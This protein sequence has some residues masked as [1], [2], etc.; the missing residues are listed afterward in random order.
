MQCS[1]W[2]KEGCALMRKMLLWLAVLFMLLVCTP[3]M[4]E[5]Y[6]IDELYASIEIPDDYIVL[7]PK[8]LSNYAQWLE[9]RESS[10][11]KT[12]SDFESRG[13]KLQAWSEKHD[14]CFELRATQSQ[15]TE[16]IFDVN[17][18]SEAVRREYRT[19][20]Y[21][22]NEYAGYDFSSSEWKNTGEN[23]R[24][25]ILK[26]VKRDN[27]EIL[28]RGFMRRTI[29]NGY[30]ID[31]DMQIHGRSA[32]DKDNSKLNKIWETFDFIEILAMPPKAAAKIAVTDEPPEETNKKSFAIEGTA[33]PGVKFTAVVM[34]L[35]DPEPVVTEA[36]AG[37][38][39]TFSLP[40]TFSKD[41]VY[42]ITLT[43]EYQDDEVMEMVYPV[44]YQ[45]TL[46]AV[47]FTTKPGEVAT[48]DSVKLAGTG[49]PGAS[50]QVFVN[51][52]AVMTKKVTAEGRFSITVE[53]EEEGPYDVALVFSKKNLADRRF[54]F[55]FTRKW[56]DADMMAYLK[57]QSISPTYSQLVKGMEKYEG[58][59][60]AFK[61]Y[62]LDVSESGDEYIV[63]MA[64]NRS[65]GKY[66]NIILVT[67][68]E[69]PNF[70]LEDRVMMYGTCEGMSLS[71]GTVD[72]DVKEESY[73]CF[74]LLLFA[75]LE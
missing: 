50:I 17:E 49:E 28:H 29:R 48:A 38:N 6:I 18:Q 70:E 8:N 3:A 32:T 64:L 66:K 15:Q 13:V 43:A 31:F 41:G 52:E 74:A 22:G 11:E 55:N 4:A 53:A 39:G 62:I 26:Y 12:L 30:Q 35:N 9:A 19:S 73:P 25:L 61:S 71:T 57:K 7:T 47:N 20:H 75:S 23:G 51:G 58:R 42:V 54:T 65:E 67:T 21:P 5:I 2:I 46:L 68:S 59:I 33:E 44:T 34:R 60:M 24:F 37:K 72:D 36:T 14:M 16:L 56:T 1:H 40:I 69:K 10:L 27:S 63:R 45:N